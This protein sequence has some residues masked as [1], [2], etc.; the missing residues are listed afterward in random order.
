VKAAWVLLATAAAVAVQTT[1]ERWTG[2]GAVDL[3]LVV[4]VYNALTSGRVAGLLTGSFAGLVQDTLSG[5]VI[6]M[7]GLSKTVVGFLAGIVGTQ[8]IVAHSASRFVVFYVATVVNAVVFMG[9]YELLGL[10]HFGTP[11][12]AVA[13]QGLGN[14]IVGVLAFKVIEMLPGAVERRRM[15]RSGLRR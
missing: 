12:A 14:A 10:R 13:G 1:M 15:A 9:L 6:G 5:G 7:A 2:A 11:F 3:V 8:F 4:V